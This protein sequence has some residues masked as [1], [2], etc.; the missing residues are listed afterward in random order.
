MGPVGSWRPLALGLGLA[1][2][3]AVAPVPGPGLRPRRAGEPPCPS[4]SAAPLAPSLERAV[5]LELAKQQILRGL[6]L[7][8]PPP[9][10]A[11]PPPEALAVALRRLRSHPE[12][13]DRGAETI[14]FAEPDATGASSASSRPACGTTLTFAL[15][16]PGGRRAQLLQ[17]R[18]WLYL[19]PAGP[20]RPGPPLRVFLR[21]PSGRT[22]LAERRPGAPG[23]HG[24]PLRVGRL[25]AAPGGWRLEL[26]LD[27]GGAHRPR[28]PRPLRLD[29]AGGR[30]R[31]RVPAC[32]P[33][34]DLCCRRHRFV[35]FRELGWGGWILQPEG[36]TMNYCAGQCPLHLAG[37]PGLAASFH[38]ALLSLLKANRAPAPA[39]QSCC[40]PTARRPLS[41]LYLDPSGSVVKADVPDMVVEACGCS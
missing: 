30:R 18:L 2:G 23:W 38:A 22:L 26:E 34:S 19:R 35:D 29:T 3:L 1:L 5:L 24:L 8:A 31:R 41:L 25:G 21:G 33:D 40:V 17:A 13:R 4:C 6:R 14:S 36:Y 28:A 12:P 10:R 16:S 32:A 11:P 37:S 20:P 39:A 27:C 9:P 7:P 15:S